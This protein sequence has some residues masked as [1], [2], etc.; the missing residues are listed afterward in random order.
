ML[1][2]PTA[3]H[4]AAPSSS[5]HPAASPKLFNTVTA[6]LA[7]D[8][9]ELLQL[10][11]HVPAPAAIQLAE[12]LPL[13][14]LLRAALP[15]D[16][17]RKLQGPFVEAAAA[18]CLIG[19]QEVSALVARELVAHL[20]PQHCVNLFLRT[21]APESVGELAAAVLRYATDELGDKTVKEALG[22]PQLACINEL[23]RPPAAMWQ[24]H[25]VW[26]LRSA[27]ASVEARKVAV[28]RFGCSISK[29]VELLHSGPPPLQ[30]EVA[31]LFKGLTC[32]T[33]PRKDEIYNAL[34]LRRLVA[35]LGSEQ[36]SMQEHV[37]GLLRNLSH[38]ED[39]RKQAIFQALDL[40][41]VMELLQSENARVLQS[42]T[43][44]LQNLCTRN[45]ERR[46]IIFS[47]LNLRHVVR[48]ME[49]G[50]VGGGGV[51]GVVRMR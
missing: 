24:R 8:L 32:L 20:P 41:R 18:R 27:S 28:F 26:M 48:L 25:A 37:A 43:G 29:L 40:R 22:L 38:G 31:A 5:W 44:L 35:L 51:G 1:P 47:H 9:L 2:A 3:E 6:R 7:V 11:L 14:A 42:I 4:A 30:K 50:V 45:E 46:E 10:M 16:G 13:E 36:P 12:S 39:R 33:G 21:R 15:R 19:M 49:V 17:Q 23:L 34:D